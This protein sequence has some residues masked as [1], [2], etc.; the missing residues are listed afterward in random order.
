MTAFVQKGRLTLTPNLTLSFVVACCLVLAGCTREAPEKQASEEVD[1][2]TETRGSEPMYSE[3]ESIETSTWNAREL[4]AQARAAVGF[5]PFSQ[6]MTPPLPASWPG[7]SDRVVFYVYRSQTLPTG[8]ERTGFEGPA[9]RVEMTRGSDEPHVTPFETIS[10]LGEQ[11]AASGW[12]EDFEELMEGAA[13]ELFRAMLAG[14]AGQDAMSS[15][16]A[17]ALREPYRIWFA[18][19]RPITEDLRGRHPEFIEWVLGE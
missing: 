7:A 17:R 2:L 4:T 3:G 12:P 11:K 19:F 13:Q 8:V 1:N 18:N 15:E 9:H 14:K 6:T 10:E 5:D 16:A